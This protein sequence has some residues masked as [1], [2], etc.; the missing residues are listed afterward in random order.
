MNTPKTAQHR[1]FP[2]QL[3]EQIRAGIAKI[4]A[5]VP[6]P[7]AAFDVDGTLWDG[8]I[9]ELFFSYQI[10]EG[11]LPR[12]VKN[13]EEFYF[14]LTR[15]NE[16]KALLWLV[17][18]NR[19]LPANSVRAWAKKCFQLH[20]ENMAFFEDQRRLVDLLRQNN[21]SV[22]FISG[23]PQWAIEPVAAHFGIARKNALGM[24][25]KIIKNIITDQPVHPLTWKEGK[26]EALLKAT[27]GQKPN[28]AVGNTMGDFALISAATHLRLA[29]CA[30]DRPTQYRKNKPDYL[31]AA[32]QRLQQEAK[33]RGWMTH[34]F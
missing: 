29:V 15:K 32:E 12:L 28:M 2:K 1:P 19:G 18:V 7:V 24:R 8:D 3:W 23:S 11:L 14:Q 10:S 25:T 33:T 17:Q 4:T 26:I 34:E 9:A 21:F 30:Q 6:R 31:A 20:R 13:P 16:D 27:K 22:Y 5:E